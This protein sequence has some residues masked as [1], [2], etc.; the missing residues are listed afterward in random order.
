LYLRSLRRAG[1][2][3]GNVK[4]T[5]VARRRVT[6]MTI[7][8]R[9]A[10]VDALGCQTRAASPAECYGLQTELAL[11]VAVIAVRGRTIVSWARAAVSSPTRA[12][13]FADYDAMIAHLTFR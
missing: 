7:T 3:I 13:F 12:K 2:S 10:L 6:L 8:T 5:A 11:R 9:R 1:A 4:A